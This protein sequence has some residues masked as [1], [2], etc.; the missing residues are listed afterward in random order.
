VER[1]LKTRCDHPQLTGAIYAQIRHAFVRAMA[2]RN[3]EVDESTKPVA[4]LKDVSSL[5]VLGDGVHVTD[6]REQL[7]WDTLALISYGFLVR[8][9]KMFVPVPF[10]DADI[11]IEDRGSTPFSNGLKDYVQGWSSGF[12]P[13]IGFGDGNKWTCATY[14]ERIIGFVTGYI[15]EVSRNADFTS[16]GGLAVNNNYRRRGIG[17]RIL[18]AFERSMPDHIRRLTAEA[19]TSSL[20]FWLSQGFRDRGCSWRY[21]N[22]RSVEKTLSEKMSS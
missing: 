11:V 7:I 5:V 20:P 18:G 17:A 21:D 1:L 10:D 2:R 9:N 12:A 13:D 22:C 14:N 16:V 15:R 4:G 8:A 6:E 19:V 3:V